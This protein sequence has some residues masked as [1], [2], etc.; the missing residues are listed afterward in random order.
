MNW[1]WM[2]TV[3]ATLAG[4]FGTVL[5]AVVS[6]TAGGYAG[7]FAWAE[8]NPEALAGIAFGTSLIAVIGAYSIM[9]SRS[10]EEYRTHWR[11]HGH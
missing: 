1:R 11:S 6:V 9:R 7:A 3:A 10:K 5:A 2:S 4:L 8:R